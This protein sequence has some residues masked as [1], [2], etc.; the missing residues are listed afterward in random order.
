MSI[1]RP[2]TSAF[3]GA[4]LHSIG[5]PM[6]TSTRLKSQKMCSTVKALKLN[7]LLSLQDYKDAR[8]RKEKNKALIMQMHPSAFASSAGSHYASTGRGSGFI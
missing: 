5:H 8:E 4:A 7:P 3:N 6:L 1:V 2:L